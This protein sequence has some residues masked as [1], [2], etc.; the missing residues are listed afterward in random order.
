MSRPDRAPVCAKA[1]SAAHSAL[2]VLKIAQVWAALMQETGELDRIDLSTEAGRVTLDLLD[3][4]NDYEYRASS[5]PAGHER[6][7][8]TLW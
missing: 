5:P 2:Q 7:P 3:S 4:V 1:T 6:G 8:A